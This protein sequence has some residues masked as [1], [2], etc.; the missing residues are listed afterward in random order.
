MLERVDGGWRRFMD[1]CEHLP[2]E[3]GQRPGVAGEWSVK[4]LVSHVATW[5]AESVAAPWA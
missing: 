4:D 2:N 5:E 3:A 1:A